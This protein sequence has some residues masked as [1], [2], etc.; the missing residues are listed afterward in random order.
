MNLFKLEIMK[1]VLFCLLFVCAFIFK[2]NAQNYPGYE[3]PNPGTVYPPSHLGIIT[4]VHYNLEDPEFVFEHE[5][6]Y[7][8]DDFALPISRMYISNGPKGDRLKFIMS[9]DEFLYYFA[10]G[11]VEGQYYFDLSISFDSYWTGIPMGGNTGGWDHQ[12]AGIIRITFP[13]QPK[14]PNTGRPIPPEL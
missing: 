13:G 9:K 11:T 12:V 14:R 4:T 2:G 6:N 7:R 8:I 1:K 5:F 10:R 3:Y